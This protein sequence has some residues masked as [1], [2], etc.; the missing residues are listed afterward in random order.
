M[1]EMDVPEIEGARWFGYEAAHPGVSMAIGAVALAG[2][3]PP[4]RAEMS[5][6][7]A[8]AC[9]AYPQLRDQARLP[10]SPDGRS[11]VEP[12]DHLVELPLPPG[13]GSRGLHQA[14][15][16]VCAEPLPGLS[17]AV[18]LLHGHDEDEFALIVRAHQGLL[19]GVS[20]AN[21]MLRTLS[22]RVP[23]R[24]R[25]RP[26]PRRRWSPG[27]V[28]ALAREAAG[29]LIPAAVP[30]VAHDTPTH[31]RHHRLWAQTSTSRLRSI[32][33]AYGA[34][35]NDVYLGALA[36]SLRPWLPAG[37]PRRRQ[38]Q[39][40]VPLNTRDRGTAAA[41]GDHV[42]GLLVPLPCHLPTAAERLAGTERETRRIT[43]SRRDPNA[44]A[45][46]DMLP[47]RWTAAATGLSLRPQRTSL[48]ATYVQGPG[49]PLEIAGRS[50]R[51]L[52]PLMSLPAG[53]RLAVGLTEYA[54][55]AYLGVVAD[56]SLPRAEEL[57][58]RWLAELDAFEAGMPE[59]AG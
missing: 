7:L 14:I 4:S 16:G 5:L 19:D 42:R 51:G 58:E 11:P 9:E 30:F 52:L 3:T 39:V 47:K 28:S 22:G 1:N 18:W 55:F 32:A 24:G 33:T 2:G 57:P 17:W 49:R 41:M 34:S 44:G 36:G 43:R 21:I 53:H 23:V 20:L 35:V 8:S 37:R 25:A 38:V 56:R 10:T 27:L 48:L 45:L 31:G 6:L 13:S 59:T 12:G 46:F 54:G 40:M 26:K 50:I 29:L 15:E